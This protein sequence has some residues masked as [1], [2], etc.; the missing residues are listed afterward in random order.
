MLILSCNEGNGSTS[1]RV[2][3]ESLVDRNLEQECYDMESELNNQVQMDSTSK[4]VDYPSTSECDK[5]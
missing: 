4:I 2:Q 5:E 1:E 3:K